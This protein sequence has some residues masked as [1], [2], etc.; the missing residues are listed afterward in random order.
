[1]LGSCSARSAFEASLEAV[2]V[3][4]DQARC[5]GRSSLLCSGS[6]GSAGQRA[7]SFKRER[8]DRSERVLF[9]KAVQQEPPPGSELATRGQ[10]RRQSSRKRKSKGR[11]TSFGSG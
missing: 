7:A 3:R 5:V 10:K 9:A 4:A 1:M 11:P 8:R 2:P 6:L